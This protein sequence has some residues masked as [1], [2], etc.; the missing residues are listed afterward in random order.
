MIEIIGAIFSL[1]YN[2]ITIMFSIV[3]GLIAGFIAATK[4]RNGYLWGIV[5][6]FYPWV[7]FIVLILP[8][9]LPKFKSYLKDNPAFVGRNPVVAS[10][11]ALSAVVAKSD[12]HVSRE[13]ITIIRK[14]IVQNFRITSFE[15]NDY[16]AAF[17][18]GKTHPKDYKEFIRIIKTYNNHY[19]SIISISYLLMAIVMHDDSYTTEEERLLKLIL[20]ELGL[21]EY[22]YQSIKRHFTVDSTGQGG[23]GQSYG[24]YGG[25]TEDLTSKYSKVLGVSEDAELGEIKKAYRKLAKE[26]HPDKLESQGMPEDYMAYA[27]ERI[28]EINEAYEYLKKNKSA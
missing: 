8:R 13:E 16:E 10:I 23:Y 15:L 21:S 5:T 1:G 22:E 9:K 3:V 11:M 26:H 4:G 19:N 6:M 14:Y 28:S 25:Q 2:I 24:A 17:E 27:N 12:G 7:I 20:G 18:Y